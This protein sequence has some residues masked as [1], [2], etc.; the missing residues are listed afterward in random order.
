M[1]EAKIELECEEGVLYDELLLYKVKHPTLVLKSLLHLYTSFGLG[2][3]D[4][5]IVAVSPALGIHTLK[6]WFEI[7]YHTPQ[8]PGRGCSAFI[9]V[10]A[11]N[12]WI[13]SLPVSAPYS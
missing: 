13:G 12:S 6:G 2:G 11:S 8:S 1:V 10:G 4:I 7:L 9:D 5:I 3:C